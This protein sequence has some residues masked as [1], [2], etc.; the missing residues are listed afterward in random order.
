M[1]SFPVSS[2]CCISHP[3]FTS[4]SDCTVTYHLDCILEIISNAP[5]DVVLPDQIQPKRESSQ[6]YHLGK[7]RMVILM[8]VL[9]R[10]YPGS[11]LFDQPHS[12]ET[13][14][15]ILVLYTY[16]YF[17]QYLL[18]YDHARD[19]DY[20]VADLQGSNSQQAQVD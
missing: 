10:I 9:G 4:Y 12:L 15:L 11:L 17:L 6:R 7:Y 16:N 20:T 8:Q 14:H 1:P 3:G 18:H 19:L 5:R 2:S 13:H